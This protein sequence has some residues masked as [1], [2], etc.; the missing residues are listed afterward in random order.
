M[1]QSLLRLG[2]GVIAIVFMAISAPIAW[3]LLRSPYLDGGLRSRDGKLLGDLTGYVT[4][5]DAGR[6]QLRVA[7]NRFGLLPLAFAVTEDTEIVVQDKL[8]GLGDLERHVRVRV[9]YELRDG[10]RVATSIEIGGG[11]IAATRAQ[12]ATVVPAPSSPVRAAAVNAIRLRPSTARVA[13]DPPR[14]LPQPSMLSEPAAVDPEPQQSASRPAEPVNDVPLTPVS[15]MPP[16]AERPAERVKPAARATPA[17]P[18]STP[19]AALSQAP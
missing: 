12:P 18:G 17:R 6:H 10:V 5:V 2:F 3:S 19:P 11:E 13:R 16:A 4:G 1:F 9:R 14:A 15:S 8:G 7:R